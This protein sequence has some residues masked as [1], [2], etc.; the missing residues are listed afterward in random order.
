MFF[1]FIFLD[2]LQLCTPLCNSLRVPLYTV[3]ATRPV[4]HSVES[5]YMYYITTGTWWSW[6]RVPSVCCSI[7][8]FAHASILLRSPDLL[9]LV[10]VRTLYISVQVYACHTWLHVL[11]VPVVYQCVCTCTIN[12]T[13]MWYLP[14]CM[15]Y[16]DVVPINSFCHSLQCRKFSI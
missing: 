10:P 2:L 14:V 4:I 12:R 11:H 13:Y 7:L 5:T 9:N 1:V 6:G 3:P 15:W 8:R 16:R